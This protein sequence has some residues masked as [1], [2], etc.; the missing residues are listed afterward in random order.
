MIQSRS[1]APP[2]LQPYVARAFHGDPAPKRPSLRGRVVRRA[3]GALAA[4]A[5]VAS[6]IPALGGV[7]IPPLTVSCDPTRVGVATTCRATITET[8]TTTQPGTIKPLAEG[9][10]T[11]GNMPSA[12]TPVRVA[13]VNVNWS[14]LEATRDV[15]T[16]GPIEGLLDTAQA[17]GLEGVR[18]RVMLGRFSPEWA[19]AI[20]DGPVPYTHVHGGTETGTVPDLWD[21][22]WQ[23]EA[24]ELFGQIAARYDADPRL[25]LIFATG[26]MTWFGEPLLRAI[27]YEPNRTNLLAAGYTRAADEALQRAQLDWLK[28]FK[29]TPVGLAYNPYQ[30]IRADGTA[31]TDLAFVS[32]LMDYHIA[33]FGSRTVLQNNSIRSSYIDAVPPLYRLFLDRTAAPG[34]TSYQTAAN[35]RIGDA[36]AT[37]AWAID[38]LSA[39]GVELVDAYPTVH[40]DAEL[41]NFDTALKANDPL[42][43]PSASVSH[44][45]SWST[46]ASGSFANVSCDPPSGGVTTCAARYTPAPGSAGDHTITA[47]DTGSSVPPVSTTVRVGPRASATTLACA[48]PIPTGGASRCSATVTDGS[49]GQVMAPTGTVG[50]SVDGIAVA[51]CAIGATSASSASCDLDVTAGTGAHQVV[52]AYRGDVD[53]AASTS[54]AVPLTVDAPPAEEPP[55]EE[56]PA[57]EPPAEEP[58]A[59]EPPAEEPPA[60]T[61]APTVAIVTPSDGAALAGGGK[62]ALTASATDDVA[63]V[64][65]VFE[66]NG[67]V[68]CTVTKPEWTCRWTPP[69]GKPSTYTI[70]ATAFDAAGNTSSDQISV[71]TVKG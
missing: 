40:T 30:F 9:V 46:S 28:A 11:R 20:G 31:G 18:L 36:D 34:T 57:E 24:A 43:G 4:V 64:R 6:L 59:E 62:V 33:S 38:Y 42:T 10:F 2:R 5:I 17:R 65:V 61:T 27:S 69:R 13:T 26:G 1:A 68:K 48:T 14:V 21:P 22:N 37:M 67:A 3:A 55:A 19:K 32:T 60:D 29:L 49:V 45:V 41:A 23:A 16:L 12:G 54:A 58:P 56:P 51:S 8:A 50:I 71:T 35:V 39:S 25:R 15:Y 52:A 66:I 47:I 7:I 44:N 63:V 70:V 53:H